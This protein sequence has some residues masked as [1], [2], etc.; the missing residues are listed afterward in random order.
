M[1]KTIEGKTLQGEKRKY[2]LELINTETSLRICHEYLPRVMGMWSQAD[3]LDESEAVPLI[4]SAFDWDEVKELAAAMLAGAS[5]E[6][7]GNTFDL[8]ENGF[9]EFMRG[10]PPEFYAAILY[11]LLANYPKYLEPFFDQAGESDTSQKP[12][13]SENE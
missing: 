2:T 6:F 13:P 9:S 1:K 5:V 7:D 12:A 10:D 4:G 3:G 11:A 8:D